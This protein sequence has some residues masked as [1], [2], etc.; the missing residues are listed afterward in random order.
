MILVLIPSSACLGDPCTGIL[1]IHVSERVDAD[2][3]AN[4]N[5]DPG[6]VYDRVADAVTGQDRCFTGMGVQVSQ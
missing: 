4:V 1:Q 2:Q 5:R 6:M 3:L